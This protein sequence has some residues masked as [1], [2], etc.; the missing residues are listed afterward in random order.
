MAICGCWYAAHASMFLT[1][2][3]LVQ[4]FNPSPREVGTDLQESQILGKGRVILSLVKE[5]RDIN[6]S[7][8]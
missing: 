8:A 5:K 4:P 1:L 3:K 6:F 7:M 2:V